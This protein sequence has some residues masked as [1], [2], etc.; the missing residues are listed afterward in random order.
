MSSSHRF[1]ASEKQVSTF[2]SGELE[3]AAHA[4]AFWSGELA[5]APPALELFTDRPR[6]LRGAP[7]FAAVRRPLDAALSAAL[8]GLGA[9]LGT[10]IGPVLVA[11][12]W[13]LLARH[14]G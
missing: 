1:A 6:T 2:R 12:L 14:A 4:I 3:G 8:D 13:V 11:S 10:G 5:G 9:R 7:A